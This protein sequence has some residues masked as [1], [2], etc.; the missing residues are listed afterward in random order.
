MLLLLPSLTEG[1]PVAKCPQP[2]PL[3]EAKLTELVKGSVPAARIGQ[4]AASCGIDFEPTGEVIGRL[5]SAGMPEGVLNSVRAAVGPAERKRKEE[6]ALWES[7]KDSQ[8]PRLF[9]QFLRE[10]PA[11]QYADA[12]GQK[13]AAVKLRGEC[14]YIDVNLGKAEPFR[15]GDTT[16]KLDDADPEHN[17][18][19]VDIMAD[20]QLLTKN[21]KLINQPVQFYTSKG[22]HF[23][24]ELV[25]KTVQKDQVIGY[26]AIPHTTDGLSTPG[27]GPRLSLPL[28][29]A[30]GTALT[31]TITTVAGSGPNNT[32][33]GAYSAGDGGPATSAHLS[34]TSFAIDAAGNV[35]IFDRARIRRIA[36][37]TGII[38]TVAGTGSEGYG[39]DNG[40][41]TAALLGRFGSLA[42]DASGNV[43]IGDTYNNRVRKISAS[44]GTITTI[45]GTG[46]A[47]AGS[48]PDSGDGGLATNAKVNNPEGLLLDANG[49]LYFASEGDRIRK[50]SAANGVIS[51]IAG[52]VGISYGGDGGPAMQAHFNNPDGLAMDGR[53][54]I[55]VADFGNQRIRMIDAAT[56]IV[57]TVVGS[58][59]LMPGRGGHPQE[60]YGGDGGPAPNAR[61]NSPASVAVDRADNLYISDF[62]NYRVRKVDRATGLI[63]T[64][65][66]TGV[67]GYGGDGGPATDAQIT[68]P[69]NIF[70]DSGGRIYF[71]DV[72]NYRIRV[73]TPV[74]FL[75]IRVVSGEGQELL[76]GSGAAKEVTVEVVDAT[77]K[78]AVG[79]PVNFI[80]PG[81]GRAGGTSELGQYFATSITNDKG[82]ASVKVKPSGLAGTWDLR[83]AAGP[84]NVSIRL[85]NVILVLPALTEAPQVLKCPQAD[86]LSEAQLTE[87]VKGSMPA[88]RIGQ[89]VA[90]CGIDFE[91]TGEAI[92]RL[93][94][95]T[96]ETVL[97]AVRAA[98]GPAERKRKEEQA[99]WES[100]KDSRAPYVFE[101]F[102]KEYP[103]GQYTEAAR[104]KFAALEPA[105][106]PA[107]DSPVIAPTSIVA[108]TSGSAKSGLTIIPVKPDHTSL[109]LTGTW[110]TAP[111]APVAITL[112]IKDSGDHITGEMK[113]TGLR[114]AGLASS[115]SSKFSGF[116]EY[117][118]SLPSDGDSAGFGFI[119]IV[120][121]LTPSSFSLVWHYPSGNDVLF[122]GLVS[123][124]H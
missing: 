93:S 12:A 18:Y 117:Y 75:K 107:P 73:L 122:E 2:G 86:P 23:M 64:I 54:N 90:S 66:G 110:K 105:P 8:Y 103:A 17:K 28:P 29:G 77:G 47:G 106:P 101:Q 36:A 20:D 94:A 115:F 4:L 50:M 25:I 88:A 92:G 52:G 118:L 123:R 116:K 24:Y 69:A 79:I 113:V 74:T 109:D 35:Y 40:P 45:A 42:I 119:E 57:T 37:S 3:S 80:F 120:E 9:E 108:G 7:I 11:S 65:A 58:G 96:P 53:G 32:D 62:L 102:L 124:Q 85:T 72:F 22:G 99:L 1:Q 100:I 27:A 56:G 10:H 63:T 30:R 78:P 34:H 31:Y 14:D 59:P 68:L 98:T 48:Y 71:G 70:V 61:L 82:L 33:T 87:L 95:G 16:M 114:K 91:P 60:G 39:G 26:L 55:Y 43:F 97:D 49:N 83:V 6:Q 13:L 21:D 111:K 76:V 19:S 15:F 104:Q 44:T 38:T 46:A 67:K 5:R 121:P 41:A 51:T 84:A 81:P 89:L 112:V